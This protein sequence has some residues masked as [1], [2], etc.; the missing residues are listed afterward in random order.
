M[1]SVRSTVLR[2]TFVVVNRRRNAQRTSSIVLAKSIAGA[3]EL[4]I[5]NQLSCKRIYVTHKAFISETSQ[6][7]Q[8]QRRSITTARRSASQ[9]SHLWNSEL[10]TLSRY[11]KNW[12]WYLKRLKSYRID[13]QTDR[14]T[15]TQTPTNGH[16]WKHSASPRYR[17]A[18]MVKTVHCTVCIA[19]WR[20]KWT[21][22]RLS[23]LNEMWF[24]VR[25]LATDRPR[26]RA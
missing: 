4:C 21:T 25:D 19:S 7:I 17:A 6:T 10:L 13:R 15:N 3:I 16:Q 14:Q 11:R 5:V 20:Q 22:V 12:W 18:Q 24:S 26:W 9:C 1:H 8:R 23:T 2:L